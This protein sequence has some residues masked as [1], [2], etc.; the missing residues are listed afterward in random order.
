MPARDTQGSLQGEDY[1]WWL[2]WTPNSGSRTIETVLRF[3]GEMGHVKMRT[4]K[5][6]FI[7]LSTLHRLKMD[8]LQSLPGY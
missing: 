5:V 1:S 3:G 7:Y 4:L 6:I 2:I 8:L